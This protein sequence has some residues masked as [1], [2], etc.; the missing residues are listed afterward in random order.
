MHATDTA[1]DVAEWCRQQTSK[2]HT[3]WAIV[4]ASGNVDIRSLEA[5]AQAH[6]IVNLLAHRT[7]APD[8]LAIA[9]RMLALQTPGLIRQIAR[10]MAEQSADE[11]VLFLMSTAMDAGTFTAA[12]QGRTSVKLDGVDTMLLRWW[13]A[14]IWWALNQA[15]VSDEPLANAFFG[16]TAQSVYPDREGQLTIADHPAGKHDT[17]AIDWMLDDAKLSTLLELGEPDAILG[18]C[19]ESYPDALQTMAPHRRYTL[20]REQLQWARQQ[21]LTSPQDHALATRIAA[22]EGPQWGTQPEWQALIDK[23]KSSGQTLQETLAALND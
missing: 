9:P 13:D 16:A 18:I 6:G 3:P 7:S 17:L 19:R 10:L 15:L 8:A 23:V 1:L 5:R 2:G 4:D 11:P 21:G 22:T 14:R 12:M 20:A